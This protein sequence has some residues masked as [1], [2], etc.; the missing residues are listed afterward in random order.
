MAGATELKGLPIVSFAKVDD[1]E[2]W[3]RVHGGA[4]PGVW[5]KFGKG[6]SVAL[7]MSK[8]EALDRALRF[9]WIDG[10]LGK[11]DDQYWLT[12]LTPRR[13]SSVWSAVN[14]ASVLALIDAGLMEPAGLAQVNLAKANGRW[15]AAYASQGSIT[16]PA[17]LEAAFAENPD[18]A[19][20]FATLTGAN[21][22][23]V[24]YRI[25]TAKLAKTR[26]ARIA[27]FV[28]M[29]AEGKVVYPTNGH[30]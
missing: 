4:S 24:L 14:R 28:A 2:A 3:L 30:E 27:K 1:W 22:Y 18:A 15:D 20:F 8:A 26:T 17:D 23:V 6:R 16:V 11:F 19:S 21:R 12:R 25:Q 7:T 5:L 10:Q 13:A 9:G 29:L